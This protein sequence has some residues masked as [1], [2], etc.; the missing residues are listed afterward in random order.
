[1]QWVFDCCVH[2]L[3]MKDSEQYHSMGSPM[4]GTPPQS[5]DLIEII[6]SKTIYTVTVWSPLKRQRER[7]KGGPVRSRTQALWLNPPALCHWRKP[8]HPPTATPPSSPFIT[9]LLVMMKWP[10]VWLLAALPFF[11]SF[12]HFNGLQMVTAQIVFDLTISIKYL[13]CGGVPSIGLST[14]W[15]HSLSFMIYTQWVDRKYCSYC[16]LN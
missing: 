5:E 1:M 10:W 11:P 9:L 14:L 8:Q 15:F 3:I 12:C 4:N 2:L 16:A 6:R 13:D 7:K